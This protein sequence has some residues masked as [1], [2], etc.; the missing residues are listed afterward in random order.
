MFINV[1][2]KENNELFNKIV[3]HSIDSF[4]SIFNLQK[5]MVNNR[6]IFNFSLFKKI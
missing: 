5:D 1:Y 3:N 4:N 2:F 6:V